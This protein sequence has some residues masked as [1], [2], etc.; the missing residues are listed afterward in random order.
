VSLS[1]ATLYPRLARLA[2]ACI[3]RAWP[4][5]PQHVHTAPGDR[6]TGLHPA[7]GGCFDWHSAVHAHWSLVRI[8]RL[9]PHAAV[10]ARAAAVLSRRLT[11][12][13]VAAEVAYLHRPEARLFEAPYGWAWV[14]ALAA[15]L[16]RLA[17]P[18]V[19]ESPRPSRYTVPAAC[20]RKALAPLAD[21][22]TARAVTY[23]R[24]LP[25]PI[26][27]GL[28]PNSAFSLALMLDALNTLGQES[29][30]AALTAAA[31][32]L[33]LADTDCPTG[34]EP[35]GSDFLSPCLAEAE[36]MRRVL[37]PAAYR[38]WLH[39]FLPPAAL[40]PLLAPLPSPAAGDGQSAHLL[41]LA[42]HRAW[43][44]HA[45]ARHGAGASPSW[46]TAAQRARQ[47][48]QGAV[49]AAFNGGYAV[50]HWLGTFILYFHSE[51]ST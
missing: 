23:F 25:V 12:T 36:L 4:Y 41:G 15:E 51:T 24:R 34:Y 10:N 50:S 26:R 5:A 49:S 22:L 1:A 46:R 32:R 47:E 9:Q 19:P 13:A 2:L 35:S 39:R 33:F 38:T 3:D 42:F 27:G 7:F 37:E 48:A 11:P 16:A 43:C 14:L 28:H 17:D 21:L 8:M 6:A 45:I 29:A 40:S 18:R 31:R 44:L 20:W 30:A